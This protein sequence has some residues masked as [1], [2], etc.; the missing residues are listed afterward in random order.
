MADAVN[1]NAVRDKGAE[2]VE[3]A[4]DDVVAVNR[5]RTDGN[6]N[7]AAAECVD[8][9]LA[10]VIRDSLCRDAELLEQHGDH[11]VAVVARAAGGRVLDGVA[12]R[13]VCL[14]IVDRSQTALGVGQYNELGGTHADE[15][16]DIIEGVVNI[17]EARSEREQRAVCN[18]HRVAVVRRLECCVHRD[19]TCAAGLVLDDDRNAQILVAIGCDLTGDGVGAAA[20]TPRHNDCNRL[21]REITCAA[22]A[23]AA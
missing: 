5:G 16:G 19:G 22:A 17:L 7:V 2:A 15:R 12:L 18:D 13:S 20:E 21:A 14:E 6:V 1:V 11:R 4:V 9:V 3:L 10:A 23:S 8:G